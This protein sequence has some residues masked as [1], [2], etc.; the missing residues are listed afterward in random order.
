MKGA[1]KFLFD[2]ATLPFRLGAIF[3]VVVCAGVSGPAVSQAQ[4]EMRRFLDCEV[5][6]NRLTC[7]SGVVCQAVGPNELGCSGGL[8]CFRGSTDL[9]CDDGWR[10]PIG[11][12]RGEGRPGV[13]PTA[14]QT[15]SGELYSRDDTSSSP[16]G[17]IPGQ[18]WTQ[19]GSNA[20]QLQPEARRFLDCEL[21]PNRL[22]CGSGVVCQA[23]GPNEL[24]C[25]G[26]L[27]CVRGATDLT[28]DDGWRY[29]VGV[30]RGERHY[31]VA[32]SGRPA[33]SPG[34]PRRVDL[35]PISPARPLGQLPPPAAD[36]VWTQG[37]L[38][39]S[40]GVFCQGTPGSRLVRC[41]NGTTCELEPSGLM[42]CN[43][44]VSANTDASGLTRF[45]NGGWSITD[46][47]GLTRRSDGSHCITDKDFGLTRCFP[48]N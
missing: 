29:P 23:V 36:C 40:G 9:L 42:R 28:C 38:K 25:S 8:K 12:L 2:L 27:K 44:G 4:P 10:Y 17:Q 14:Q 32:T 37:M 5:A 31:G 34:P 30:L 20:S 41:S 33:W 6:P 48:R 1:S 26:G 16:T 35:P 43:G 24:G 15:Q 39:C 13:A 21:A 18:A 7:S 11:V 46:P 3:V 19:G 22:T 47:S 45:S